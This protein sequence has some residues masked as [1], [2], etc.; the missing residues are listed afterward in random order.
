MNFHDV[1]Q[2]RKKKEAKPIR[3]DSLYH[4][5]MKFIKSSIEFELN[6]ISYIISSRH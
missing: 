3:K 5:I 1:E 6:Q 2:L 4:K